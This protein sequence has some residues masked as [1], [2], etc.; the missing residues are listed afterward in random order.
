[1]MIIRG[2]KKSPSSVILRQVV[3]TCRRRRRTFFQPHIHF[4]SKNVLKVMVLPP[5][6]FI[7]T[8]VQASYGRTSFAPTT[9]VHNPSGRTPHTL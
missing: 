5:I 7:L 9:Y 2:C 1:M 3:N 8:I 4:S 6:S